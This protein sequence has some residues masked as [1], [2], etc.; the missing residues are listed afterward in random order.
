MK[1]PNLL[2]HILLRAKDLLLIGGAVYAIFVWVFQFAS[3]PRRLEASEVQIED[4]RKHDAQMDV[5]VVQMQ[6]DIR[7]I[8]DAVKEIKETQKAVWQ[9][10]RKSTP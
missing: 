4:S 3:I 8:A 6:T 7:Y 1:D 5:T 10:L 2:D 9:T